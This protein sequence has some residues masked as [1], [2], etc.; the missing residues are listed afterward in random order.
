MTSKE[1]VDP[2]DDDDAEEELSSSIITNTPKI[3]VPCSVCEGEKKKKQTLRPQPLPLHKFREPSRINY[4]PQY[5]MHVDVFFSIYREDTARFRSWRELVDMSL[6]TI[7]DAEKQK[8]RGA[9]I[10]FVRIFQSAFILTS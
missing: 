7:M 2:R 8:A 9:E 4:F 10:L 5:V 1:D 6:I 3:F